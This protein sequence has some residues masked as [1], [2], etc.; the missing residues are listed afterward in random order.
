M[1]SQLPHWPAGGARFLFDNVAISCASLR[2]GKEGMGALL[3]HSMGLGKT[4]TT[5]A[6]IDALLTSAA[7]RSAAREGGVAGFRCVLVVAP[8]TVLQNWCDEAEKWSERAA[9]SYFYFHVKAEQPPENP[10]PNPHPNLNPDPSPN[11]R[12]NPRQAEQPLKKRIATLREWQQDGGVAVIGYEA[13]LALLKGKAWREATPLLQDPGPDLIVLDEGHRI[14]N[15]QG[16]LHEAL[17]G[18]RTRR[19]LILT[20]TPM[21]NN[22]MEYH[23][24]VGFVRPAHLGTV[25]EFKNRFVN[26]IVNGNTLDAS[27][28]DV[29]LSRQRMAVL[30]D[31]VQPFLHRRSADILR[32]ALPPKSD[33]TLTLTFSPDPDPN[34][35]TAPGAAAQVRDCARVP[36]HAGAA[37]ALHRLSQTPTPA[38][39]FTLTRCSG[40]STPPS[41]AMS[42]ARRASLTGGR[43]ACAGSSV[44]TRRCSR[45]ST[46][47]PR[48]TATWTRKG[49]A[50]SSRASPATTRW[51]T[52]W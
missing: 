13:M 18:V 27:A 42:R 41:S 30:H 38:L 4:L 2:A 43:R 6:L 44:A 36:P 28:A 7:L 52:S 15:M 10:N 22:L 50:T 48:S 35:N 5:I 8:A 24:M 46:T 17:S 49:R 45:S 40:S 39:T 9:M 20:G 1:A 32:Q 23:A 19:R 21:Q 12:P 37:A 3:A 33:L 26:P 14:K 51:M 29:R 47:P 16:K 31:Q 34:P 25:G 11:P